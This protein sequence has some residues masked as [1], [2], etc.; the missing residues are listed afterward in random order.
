MRVILLAPIVV[1]LAACGSTTTPPV[2]PETVTPI[3]TTPITTS[4]TPSRAAP[5]ATVKK[6][7]HLVCPY[8][9]AVAKDIYD[10]TPE[11]LG[12]EPGSSIYLA[13]N[14]CLDSDRQPNDPTYWESQQA[15]RDLKTCIDSRTKVRQAAP[16][17]TSVN[18]KNCSEVRAAGKAPIHP[19]DPGW[20]K[21][22]DRDNDGIGCE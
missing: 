20:Q 1:L 18:F 10:C 3:T 6:S 12:Q 11:K 16:S 7:T 22:F 19:G 13:Y 4:S 5:K 14:Y 2:V 15:F 8:T 21:K 17:R 9:D